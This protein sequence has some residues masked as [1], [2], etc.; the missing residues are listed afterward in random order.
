MEYTL[1]EAAELLGVDQKTLRKWL[2]ESSMAPIPDDV[3]LRRRL[4]RH[5]QLEELAR[6]HR[7][8]LRPD[9]AIQATVKAL[10]RQ[11]ADLTRAVLSLEARIDRR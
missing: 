11:V 9:D 3:D 5:E 8:S 6:K 1:Q 10:Q 7:R 4:L 2:K